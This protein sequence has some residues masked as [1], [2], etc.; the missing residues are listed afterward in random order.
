[1][2]DITTLTTKLGRGPHGCWFSNAKSEL[3]YPEEG[4]HACFEVEDSSFWFQHRNRCITEVVRSFAP[5]GP[6]FDVGG[7]NG[8]VAAALERSR[9]GSRVGRA[10]A[11][12]AFNA[13]RRGV[14]TV[15]ALPSSR[16][17]SPNT[18]SPAWGCSTC[19][20][21]SRT[22]W[23]SSR[24]YARSSARRGRYSLP[25]RPIAA[26]GL[27]RTTTRATSAATPS[28][29]SYLPSAAPGSR[30][31]TRPTCSG[32]CPVPVFLFRTLPGL[33]RRRRDAGPDADQARARAAVGLEGDVSSTARSRGV[34]RDPRPAARPVRRELPRRGPVRLIRADYFRGGR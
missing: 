32:S 24:T 23:G 34:E 22:T 21:T 10:G 19:S 1:M 28:G 31:T 13:R 9:P 11:G 7:G 14:Q 8:V 18:R 5:A 4:N 12:G 30:S 2:I 20:S 29:R 33:F 3:S 25:S 27:T 15:L 6:L 26:C 17:S 16:P